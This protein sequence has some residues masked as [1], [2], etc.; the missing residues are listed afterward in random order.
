MAGAL[1][2]K[3]CVTVLGSEVKKDSSAVIKNIT[4]ETDYLDLSH[5]LL[6]LRPRASYSISLSFHFS[7]FKM[8]IIEAFNLQ[9]YY[10]N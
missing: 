3:A 1:Q 7:H 6:A 9:G 5:Q 8:G 4:L 2:P 10:E